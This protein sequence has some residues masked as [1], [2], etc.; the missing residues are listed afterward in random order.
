METN[1]CDEVMENMQKCLMECKTNSKTHFS[2]T[3]LHI[4]NC[5]N[6]RFYERS[7]AAATGIQIIY[8]IDKID[9]EK[10]YQI[11]YDTGS[12]VLTLF[13]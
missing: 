2:K 4:S 6:I 13:R 11:L 1:G 10:S 8:A 3:S 12:K 7:L 9:A 5:E